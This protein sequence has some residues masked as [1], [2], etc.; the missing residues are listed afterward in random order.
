MC[1][2][3]GDNA[4]DFGTTSFSTRL[5]IIIE[6]V[7]L[8]IQKNIA[9]SLDNA[10][11]LNVSALNTPN[12]KSWSQ[13]AP[14]GVRANIFNLEFIGDYLRDSILQAGGDED[15]WV[16]DPD[17]TTGGGNDGVGGDRRYQWTIKVRSN[18]TLESGYFY[19]WQMGGYINN[20]NSTSQDYWTSNGRWIRGFMP[21]IPGQGVTSDLVQQ[22]LEVR[23][24]KTA[25]AQ[26][27]NR[28]PSTYFFISGSGRVQGNSGY[29]PP[30]A[31]P[32]GSG[33]VL[34]MS[35]S[36]LNDAYNNNFAAGDLDYEQGPNANF[37]FNQEPDF[38]TFP[39]IPVDFDI[40]IGVE[41][42]FENNEAL[43][44]RIVGPTPQPKSI[45][46]TFD[47]VGTQGNG[48]QKPM[49]RLELDGI[50]PP[51]TNVDFFLIRRFENS[52][53]LVI[54]DQQKPY[55]VIRTGSVVEV[56]KSSAPGI[57]RPEFLIPELNG[58]PDKIF[59]DLLE[60]KILT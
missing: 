54:L 14:N 35:S 21:N 8:K 39:P 1:L 45:V 25:A 52:R 10:Q 41:I 4:E 11:Y 3:R 57:L 56:E 6:N 15:D 20:F 43:S 30:L 31:E 18:E 28:A 49:L 7:E 2:M 60:K 19:R 58:S 37:P 53:N 46:E 22:R 34:L 26:G 44:Y 13:P 48:Q 50:I 27:F 55:G 23:G 12:A 33:S 32:F 47:M 24:L 29:T 40:R 42:R 36:I 38:I 9:A 51:S 59:D 5:K 17:S 16:G